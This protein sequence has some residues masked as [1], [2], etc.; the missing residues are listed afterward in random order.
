MNIT[1][2]HIDTKRQVGT[3][4]GKPVVEIVT[5]GGLCLI[6][7]PKGTGVETC[8][9]GP[10]KAVAKHLARKRFPDILWTALE[11]SEEVAAE[12]FEDILPA[13]E[14]FTDRCNEFD[15]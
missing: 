9:A 13:C 2:A 3:L 7:T 14:A 4:K 8:G 6:V 11:K 15:T 12:H 5:T 10:H 1:S